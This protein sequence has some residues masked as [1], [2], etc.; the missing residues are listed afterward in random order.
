[1]EQWRV[2]PNCD[3]QLRSMHSAPRRR[4]ARLG[5]HIGRATERGQIRSRLGRGRAPSVAVAASPAAWKQGRRDRLVRTAVR[6][7]PSTDSRQQSTAVPRLR[8]PFPRTV[9]VAR[10]FSSI[11]IPHI[12]LENW[13]PCTQGVSGLAIQTMRRCSTLCDPA[14]VV[15]PR[16]LNQTLEVRGAVFGSTRRE[17][18]LGE[19]APSDSACAV[20][21]RRRF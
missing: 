20:R 5:G 1:M 17:R 14:S 15:K 6:R 16:R 8:D 21:N 4:N 2:I 19:Q 3:L 10:E 9:H 18:E 13:V 11:W 7:R 12:H